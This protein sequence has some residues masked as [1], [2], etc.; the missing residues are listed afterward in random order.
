MQEVL[1]FLLIY[2][3][4]FVW[5]R[6][7]L[8]KFYLAVFVSLAISAC[9]DAVWLAFKHYKLKKDGLKLKEK[10]EAQNM[11]LSLACS[12]KPIEFY[13]KLAAKKHKNISL[14]K[15]YLVIDYKEENVKTLLYAD[16]SFD[17]LT[18][19]RFMSIYAKIKKEHASK[20]VIC[21][22]NIADKE[23]G[24]FCANF[25]EKFL[26]LDQ[27]ATYE[28]LYKYYNCFPQVTKTYAT[29]KK[30]A[31]KDFMAYSFNKKRTKGYLFSAFVLILSGLFI[32]YSIYY[33]VVASLLIVFALISQFN[34]YFNIKSETEIL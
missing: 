30:M 24:L 11:F 25:K 27:Y 5:I 26:L 17:G 14:H 3:F 10:E 16:F 21:C 31:F 6:Y 18:V 12:D 1:K 28:K 33:C 4:T 34:P 20:I 9:V 8:R 32:P 13:A 22:K 23:L 29:S 2:L 15:D 19:A 7:F